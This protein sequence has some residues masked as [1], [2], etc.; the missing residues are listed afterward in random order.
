MKPGETFTKAN[1]WDIY[2]PTGSPDRKKLPK[3]L[4]HGSPKFEG[5]KFD[6]G[7][8]QARDHGFYG[9]GIYLTSNPGTASHYSDPGAG[10]F[11]NEREIK[12]ASPEVIPVYD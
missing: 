9:E 7:K 3:T 11:H 6:L 1:Q 12:G 2:Q 4:Y 8:T 5:D 10:M